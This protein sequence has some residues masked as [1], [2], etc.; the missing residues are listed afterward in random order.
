[1]KKETVFLAAL[2]HDIGKFMQRADAHEV[3]TSSLLP[4]SIKNNIDNFCPTYKGSHLSTHLLWTAAFIEKYKTFF[5][6][7]VGAD[8]YENFFKTCVKHHLPD[9]DDIYQQIVQKANDYASGIERNGEHG[10]NVAEVGKNNDKNERL[11]SIFEGIQNNNKGFNY[12]LP[13]SPLNFEKSHHFQFKYICFL[14]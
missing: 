9:S 1:M 14:I 2:L 6:K 8:E 5:V 11:V 12:R 4:D 7:A 13:I 10:I 3:A